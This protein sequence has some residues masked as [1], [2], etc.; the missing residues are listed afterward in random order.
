[1]KFRD[2]LKEAD[3]LY[4]NANSETEKMKFANDIGALI[5]RKYIKN[6]KTYEARGGEYFSLP[7]GVTND[8]ICQIYFDGEL[9]TGFSVASILSGS[10]GHNVRIKYIDIPVYGIDDEVPLSPPHHNI[11]LYYI[12]AFICLHCGDTDSYNINFTLYN[13]Y[14]Q[15]FEKSLSNSEGETL[16]YK[17]LW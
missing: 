10:E 1:M 5:S 2:I 6:I 13:T 14:L 17:N 11:Y 12:L 15:E 7:R 16:R 3:N 8:V 4:P 9:Q